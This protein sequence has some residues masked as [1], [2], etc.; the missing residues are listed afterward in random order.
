[1]IGVSLPFRRLTGEQ[2]TPF[3][4]IDAFL[5]K[6]KNEGVGSI[7][8][9]A[10]STQSDERQV[11]EAARKIWSN[12]MN[13]TVHGNIKS[14][15]TAV[16]DVFGPLSGMLRE[17]RQKELIVTLHPTAYDN[18]RILTDLSDYIID[19]K[20]PVRI[21]LEN[22]RFLPNKERGDC[23]GLVVDI[24]DEVNRENIGIC[25]DMGHYYYN[26]LIDSPDDVKV[27][28]PKEFLKKVIH[29][30]IHA[31]SKD[32]ATHFPFCADNDLPLK[33]YLGALGHNYFGA[34]NI[35]IDY[36]K[37]AD[38]YDAE[39]AWLDSVEA[40]KDATPFCGKFYDEIRTQFNDNLKKASQVLKDDKD[41]FSLVHS[42]SYI[43]NTN[44][45]RFG[46]D[47]AFR[48]AGKL[49]GCYSL[50]EDYFASLDF[51]LI[52]HSHD[53]HFDPKTAEAL[54]DSNIKWIIPEFMVK[55]AVDCGISE[56]K[57]IVSKVGEKI[58]IDDMEIL[59]FE[60]K[61]FRLSN[62]QGIESMGY[63]VISKKSPSMLFL[64]DVRDY[65]PGNIS[66]DGD[67][68]Y[69]FSHVW[70]GDNVAGSDTLVGDFPEKFVNYMASFKPKNI[71]LA[72]L[73]ESGRSRN[74]MWKICHATALS[75]L[76]YAEYP[77]IK[78]HIPLTGDIVT[79]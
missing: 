34:Y 2:D 64:G 73:Y 41:A 47:L 29:T 18:V 1:M 45:K 24:T 11:L 10:V 79:I 6:L 26:S 32:R 39:K 76:F 57:I 52:T 48:T 21:A 30:H 43:V 63:Y 9:R 42:S 36:Q 5:K 12:G 25:F 44:G 17:L 74:N 35:E 58:L 67:V 59:P 56:D 28:P 16:R 51:M 71:V 38:I 23:I 75:E 49:S 50:L 54:K 70:L 8:L 37:F 3:A 33:E 7:E 69:L 65:T 15:E 66:I 61:H 19:N 60:G 72:H 78:V 55:T 40:V 14:E 13:V 53:D 20:L 46:V 77:Q 27:L 4:D 68:D 22:N 62:G 31:L